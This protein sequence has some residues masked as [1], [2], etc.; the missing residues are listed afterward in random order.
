MK[1]IRFEQFGEPGQVLRLVDL[2]EPEPGRNRVRVRMIASPVNP[3]DLLVVRGRYGVLP[4]LPATPGFEGVGVVDRA[5]PGLLGR[6][7]MGKRV[8]VINDKGGKWAAYAVINA[9]EARPGPAD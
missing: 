7:A 9:P 3:S 6:L 2:P 8:T 4:K 5:G 1:A